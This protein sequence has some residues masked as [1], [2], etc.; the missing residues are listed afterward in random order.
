MLGASLPAYGNMSSIHPELARI[1]AETI[2]RYAAADKAHAA[3]RDGFVYVMNHSLYSPG[4]LKIGHSRDPATRAASAN[5]NSAEGFH[6]IRYMRYFKDR[7]LV[8]SLAHSH[9]WHRRVQGEHFRISVGEA[10]RFIVSI[11]E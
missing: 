4:I 1:R 6:S 2:R 7:A 5:T 3:A 11:E 10:V 8:E 9:F